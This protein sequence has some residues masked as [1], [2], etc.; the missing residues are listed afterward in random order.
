MRVRVKC[1]EKDD[2]YAA[3][4]WPKKENKMRHKKKNVYKSEEEKENEIS[5]HSCMMTLILMHHKSITNVI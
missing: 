4:I 5:I 2:D 1:Y 3:L